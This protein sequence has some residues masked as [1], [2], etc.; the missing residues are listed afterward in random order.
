MPHAAFLD[1]LKD[2]TND[3][4]PEEAK[5]INLQTTSEWIDTWLNTHF[6][7]DIDRE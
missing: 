2:F 5:K 6:T 1:L 4:F 7:Y 3:L